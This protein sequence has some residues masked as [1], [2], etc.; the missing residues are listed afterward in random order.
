MLAGL[1]ACGA[2]VSFNPSGLD[3]EPGTRD[4]SNEPSVHSVSLACLVTVRDRPKLVPCDG[5][6]VPRTDA[7]VVVWF[8][9]D[10]GSQW[11]AEHFIGL[12]DVEL[13]PSRHITI[14]GEAIPLY[15]LA[16]A[17][18]EIRQGQELPP[19]RYHVRVQVMS[20]YGGLSTMAEQ[21]V[22]IQ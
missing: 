22:V 5:A 2:S 21:D 16:D 6:V 18:P 17:F 11:P 14:D 4:T 9:G 7:L 20:L 19:A 10:D 1:A 13:E 3:Y 12:N 8:H 15:A